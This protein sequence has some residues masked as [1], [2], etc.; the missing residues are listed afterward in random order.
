[1]VEPIERWG[2]LYAALAPT[3]ITLSFLP[4]FGVGGTGVNAEVESFGSVWD[5]AGTPAGTPARYAAFLILVMW[6]GL[7]AAAVWPTLL[8]LPAV[9]AGCAAIIGLVLWARPR[10][11]S[12]PPN[13]SPVGKA[14]MLVA[15][16]VVVVS[17]IHFV[18]LRAWT[19]RQAEQYTP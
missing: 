9:N 11:G 14:Q 16:G 1:V 15:V 3:C 7:L 2:R 4:P 8:A 10:T 6:G 18:A 17:A 13:L 12:P 19:K 5:M